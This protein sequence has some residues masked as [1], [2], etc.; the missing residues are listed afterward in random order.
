MPAM[1]TFAVQVFERR[2][3]VLI[4][5]ARLPCCSDVDA[6]AKAVEVAGCFGGAVALSLLVSDAGLEWTLAVLGVFGETAYDFV[7][8]LP[9]DAPVGMSA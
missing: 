5:G 8:N 9:P 6:I 1:P 3:D 7:E 2:D 4:W